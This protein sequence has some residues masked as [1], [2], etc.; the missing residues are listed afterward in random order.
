MAIWVLRVHLGRRR[1]G[2]GRRRGLF[3]P[4]ASGDWVGAVLVLVL[5]Y[6]C[7]A[8][9]SPVKGGSAVA[10][11]II[12]MQVAMGSRSPER[13]DSFPTLV[14]YWAGREVGLRNALVR[15]LA[16]RTA[17][18]HA[19]QAAFAELS[20]QRER[21]RIARELHDIVAHHLAVVVV[22]AG[23]GRMARLG[24]SQRTPERFDA[25]RQSRGKR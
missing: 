11:M 21:A 9:A 16:Q 22:Q 6:G 19:E 8:Y 7:G 14:P 4:S 18:L 17:E 3:V 5:S 15:R 13:R 25:V 20:V 23:A 10:A 1:P 12:A 24:P 2:G